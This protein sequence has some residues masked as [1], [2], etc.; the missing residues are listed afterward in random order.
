MRAVAL[1]LSALIAAAR[2]DFGIDTVPAP[3]RAH[4]WALRELT[5]NLL[6]N[7]VRHSPAGAALS[8]MLHAR[9]GQAVLGVADGGPGI[10]GELRQRLFQPF[11]AA[12]RAGGAGL[13]L[14]ICHE[15]VQSL[16]GTLALDN[17]LEGERV[18]G[19]QATVRLPLAATQGAA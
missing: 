10:D 17:R 5:R 14:A 1:D 7:A 11:G 2:L 15:I 16:G 6:H 18:V 13:G 4:E 3:V 9:D 19:L 8:V 12:G